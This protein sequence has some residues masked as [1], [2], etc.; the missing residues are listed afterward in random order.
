MV[1]KGAKV[2]QLDPADASGLS[3]ALGNSGNLRAPT[4]RA[5]K[6]W[7]VGFGEAAWKEFLAG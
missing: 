6:T 4:A 5:G 2:T 1:C 3:L 7:F